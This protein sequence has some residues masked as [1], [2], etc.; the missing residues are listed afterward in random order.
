[1]SIE[2]TCTTFFSEDSIDRL[3]K[4][5]VPYLDLT[6][7]A[8]GIG[9]TPGRIEFFTREKTV[10]CGTEE[11]QRIF[12]RL[13]IT[14]THFLPSGS[15]VEPGRLLLAAEGPA[16]VLHIAWKVCLNILEYTSGIAT[17]TRKLVDL[18]RAA[19][20]RTTIVTTRKGFP[21]TKELSIKAVL[22]GGGL[23]HRLGLSETILVFD[24]HRAFLGAAADFPA[25]IQELKTKA[26]EKKVLVEVESLDQA[27]ELASAGVDGVQFDKSTP[28]ETKIAVATLRAINP[29]LVIISAG[30][31]NES[32]AAAY[33]ATGIDAI[34]TSAVYFGKP[35]DFR[36][37]IA[38][39]PKAD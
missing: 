26:C 10:L 20:P 29:H 17:R 9:N 24:Q 38:P 12:A 18:A 33:A 28:E 7:W 6:T 37:T 27:V 35:A 16:D 31:V 39:R 34:A 15:V 5:D 36:V 21:G 1:M 2:T 22:V 11:A 19:N 8:L 13:G 14:T 4:E 25:R 3:I 30:G 23:P 32:N